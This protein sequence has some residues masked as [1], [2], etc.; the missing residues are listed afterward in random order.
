MPKRKAAGQDDMRQEPKRRSARL[1]ALPV[2]IT[3]E[4]KSKRTSTPRKMKTK[5]MMEKNSYVSAKAVAE[6]KKEVVKDEYNNETAENGEAKIIEEP[7]SG[8][9]LEE[10][11]EEKFEDVKEE[12]GKKREAM[13]A[14]V[15]E[16]EK[17]DQKE[18]GEDQNEEEKEK[19]G[20]LLVRFV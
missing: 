12:E 16:D 7:A 19:D 4:L 18:Y 3:P 11:N 5:N 8:K 15:K 1:S 9:E 6:T 20:K 13:T 2:P 14:E 17:E 10:T